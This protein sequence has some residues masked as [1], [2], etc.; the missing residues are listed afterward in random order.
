[1]SERR[2]CA[3]PETKP[4]VEVGS[5]VK[6]ETSAAGRG[7]EDVQ[8]H[9]RDAAGKVVRILVDDGSPVEYDQPLM[10]VEYRDTKPNREVVSDRGAR[11]DVRLNPDRQPGRDCA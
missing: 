1:M 11:L 5:I 4:F 6:V 3:S 2:I 8:R 9:C 7:D 10:I